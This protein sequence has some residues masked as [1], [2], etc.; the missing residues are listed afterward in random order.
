MHPSALPTLALI[1]IV[2]VSLVGVL[3]LY[4][5]AIDLAVR[6]STP[7][8]LNW[9]MWRGNDPQSQTLLFA[10]FFAWFPLF[11]AALLFLTHEAPATRNTVIAFVAGCLLGSIWAVPERRFLRS[12]PS[13]WHRC[14]LFAIF[15]VLVSL[16]TIAFV[17]RVRG[18]DIPWIFLAGFGLSRFSWL[19][20][21]PREATGGSA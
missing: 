9:R 11:I 12:H 20:V 21:L 7:Q 8:A 19:H 10:S 17:L 4:S 18:A 6:P 16:L 14:H 3:T 5:H 15:A 2:A 13:A 1:P